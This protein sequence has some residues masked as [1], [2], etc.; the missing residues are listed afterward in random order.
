MFLIYGLETQILFIFLKTHFALQIILIYLY[1]YG[2]VCAGGRPQHVCG[3]RLV[4]NL[5][6]SILS[7][8]HASPWINIRSSGLAPSTIC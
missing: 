4:D 1:V 2:N 7:F 8:H 6:K 3:Y 5:W